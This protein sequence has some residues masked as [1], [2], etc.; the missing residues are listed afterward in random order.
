M[1]MILEHTGVV[2]VVVQV[3]VKVGWRIQ[4]DQSK[5]TR[6]VWLG[7]SS[8]RDGM[9]AAAFARICQLSTFCFL[10]P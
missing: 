2:V 7:L 1:C 5:L 10:F 4:S 6:L 3:K 8:R 9:A